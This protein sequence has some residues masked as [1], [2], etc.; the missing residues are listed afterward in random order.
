M[1]YP[2]RITALS[3][4]SSNTN[5]TSSESFEVIGIQS[6]ENCCPINFTIRSYYSLSPKGRFG[7]SPPPSIVSRYNDPKARELPFI[8]ETQS[9]RMLVQKHIPFYDRNQPLSGWCLDSNG[10]ALPAST[11]SANAL[12]NMSAMIM[13]TGRIHYTKWTDDKN[14]TH[15]GCEIIAEQV[16]FLSKAKAKSAD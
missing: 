15:Y 10:I 13:V 2:A 5:Q 7:K 12:Q 6:F 4:A 1:G 11:A 9:M 16:D 14:V 8:P 3:F